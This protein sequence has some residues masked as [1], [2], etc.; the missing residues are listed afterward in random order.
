MLAPVPMGAVLVNV[1]TPV[2]LGLPLGNVI[3]NGFGVIDTVARAATPVPVSVTGAI[4]APVPVTVRVLE[5]AATVVGA[6]TTF[7][8]HV[9]P[10]ANVVPQVPPGVPVGR[11]N[12]CGV[13]P[14][15]V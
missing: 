5:K 14:P 12:G 13:P 11:W 1:T 4:V 7:T 8:V 10:T 2:P 9:A 6:N 3:V 15:N